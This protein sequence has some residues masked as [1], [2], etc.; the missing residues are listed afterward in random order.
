LTQEYLSTLVPHSFFK[1]YEAKS[2]RVLVFPM[3]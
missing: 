2:G 3:L 1:A